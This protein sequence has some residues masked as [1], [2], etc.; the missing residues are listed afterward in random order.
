[1]REWIEEF[2]IILAYSTRTQLS[3]FFGVVF[4]F[5]NILIG[6]HFASAFTFQG[7][8]VPLADALLPVIE[9][10]YEKLAWGSLFAFL[11]LANKCYKKDRKRLFSSL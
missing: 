8:L 5:G 6:H 9:H 11:L 10:R 3:I 1:M 7:M 2:V 4:F